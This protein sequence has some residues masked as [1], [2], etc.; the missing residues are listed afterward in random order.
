MTYQLPKVEL[1]E[2]MHA[3]KPAI[4]GPPAAQRTM[5][6]LISGMVA[7]GQKDRQRQERQARIATLSLLQGL[8]YRRLTGNWQTVKQI[9]AALDGRRSAGNVRRQLANL[10]KLELAAHH[11]GGYR[12]VAD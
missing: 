8:I 6:E 1:H 7:A 3:T 4:G 10:V 2:A 12:L 5:V 11:H 9:L